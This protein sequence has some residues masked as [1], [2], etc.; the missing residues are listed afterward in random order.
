MTIT[1]MRYYKTVCQY[2]SLTKASRELHVS[3]PAL[4]MAIKEIENN[5]GVALFHHNSNSLAITEIGAALLDEITNIIDLCDHLESMMTEHLLDRKYVRVGFVSMNGK[6][7]IL[8]MIS[9][10]R[11]QHPDIQ[12]YLTEDSIQQHYKALDCGKVDV[13]IAEKKPEMSQEEWNDSSLYLHKKLGKINM[14]FAV[15]ADHPLAKQDAVSWQEIAKLPLVLFD[16]SHHL[17]LTVQRELE[18]SRCQMP[19]EI[20]YTTQISTVEQFIENNVACGF[21]PTEVIEENPCIHGLSCPQIVDDWLY[22]VYRRDHHA[23]LP[24]RQFIQT[25]VDTF[26]AAK[27]A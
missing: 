18:A 16:R 12:L 10:F 21:L 19:R 4:S 1:Q 24:I 25:A 11:R 9:D 15:S 26:R 7:A 8:T 14:S 23:S 2:M 22:L 3:Q 27:S 20:Y 5:Y 17:T 13:I 6:N